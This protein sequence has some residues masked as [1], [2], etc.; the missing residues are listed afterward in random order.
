VVSL[1]A[2]SGIRPHELRALRWRAILGEVLSVPTDTKTGDRAVR[3][4]VPLKTDLAEWRLACGRPAEE[5]LVVPSERGVQ[6][7]ANGFE[8]WQQRVLKPAAAKIGRPDMTAYHLRHSFASLLAHDGR[9]A[10]YIAEQLGHG[11]D[12]SVKTYQ[13]VIKEYEHAPRLAAE[14][15]IRQA[16]ERRLSRLG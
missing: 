3:L 10:V 6:W 11:P 15:A 7:T 2:H 13:H 1:L 9:S 12:V 4:L 8:K 16:R 14:D 5:W